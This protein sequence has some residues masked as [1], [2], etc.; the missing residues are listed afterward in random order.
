MEKYNGTI[1][2]PPV[3]AGTFLFPLTEGCTHNKCTFCNMYHGVRFR[4]LPLEELEDILARARWG[5]RHYYDKIERVYFVGADPF[6]LP[7]ERL[8]ERIELVRR[9]L[10]KAA[11]FTMYARVENVAR[12]SDADLAALQQAGVDDL[13]LGIECGLDD[14]LD[15]MKKGYSTAEIREQ[16]ARLNE[17]GIHHSDLLMLGCGGAGRWL[18]CA[19]A[20]AE[21]ENATR[22]TQVLIN[23]ISAFEG[24]Q[25]QADI[26]SGKFVPASELECLQEERELLT[27]MEDEDLYFW[28]NHPLDAVKIEGIVGEERDLMLADLDYD[29]AHY[30]DCKINRVARTGKL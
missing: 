14:V 6:A 26:E 8:L 4:V 13:Y 17:A 21:L 20:T 30:G 9:H 29:I 24:T 3:E 12:K 19:R 27:L 22:P 1:Y 28:A 7:A 18:E 5:Y 15:Y 10:P 23:T 25:L 16:C 2:R 11:T